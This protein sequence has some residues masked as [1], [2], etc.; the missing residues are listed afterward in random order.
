MDTEALGKR[1]AAGD[2]GCL[3]A[4]VGSTGTG[5]V[6]PLPEILR[7]RAQHGFRLHVDAA[8]GGYFGLAGNL[9]AETRAAFNWIGE[10]DSIVVDPHKHG[11]Q[12]YGCG[13]VLFRD[14]SVGALYKHDSPYTYFTSSELHL[15]EISLE[16]S[17]PGASAV[18][19]WAT[20]KL[21]PL[22]RGGEFAAGLEACREAAVRLAERLTADSRWLVPFEPELDIVVWAPRAASTQLAS[23]QSQRIFTAAAQRGLHLALVRL[24][25]RYFPDFEKPQGR[26]A[27]PAAPPET[28]SREE[29]VL[30]LRSVLMKPEHREWLD[31][32]W[33]ILGAAYN[34]AC[35]AGL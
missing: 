18:A 14:P 19:L 21:L 35:S 8:Y 2:I 7:L 24:P 20:Q 28:S 27:G 32:I 9:A 10:A 30:C 5:S 29:M 33:E 22:A 16:C 1:L 15:G 12:P 11:L 31:Q 13:C 4:T 23:K 6:D 17:R 26:M 25:V 3:V 34:D